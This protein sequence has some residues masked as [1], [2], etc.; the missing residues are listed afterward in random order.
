MAGWLTVRAFLP[1]PADTQNN[2]PPSSAGA[3][4]VERKEPLKLDEAAMRR[5]ELEAARRLVAEVPD[6]PEA[7]FILGL[8]YANRGEA[9]D[10]E[11]RFDECL[12]KWPNFVCG[13]DDIGAFYLANQKYEKALGLYREGIRRAPGMAVFHVGEGRALMQLGR[14]GEAATALERA[15]QPAPPASETYSLLGETYLHMKD[16]EKAR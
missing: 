12:R 6:D 10:A 11:T 5:E 7:V 13:Y 1:A 3:P 9:A 15:V 16:Y 4:A 2:G 8:V 14:Y